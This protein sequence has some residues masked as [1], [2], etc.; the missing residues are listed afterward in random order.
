MKAENIF[1]AMIGMAIMIFAASP[2]H[3]QDC[4]TGDCG[5]VYADGY[6]Y[7]GSVGYL[8]GND[9]A[10]NVHNWNLDMAGQY[11]WHGYNYHR[12]WGAPLALVVPP[13]SAFETEYNWGVASTRSIPIYHQYG[14]WGLTPSSCVGGGGGGFQPTPY[15]PHS[16]S[17]FGVYPVRGPW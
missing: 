3:G 6:G 12:Q 13:T 9:Y 1:A 4:A 8:P 16:T 10:T 14:Y 7:G 5:G 2:I 17:Q 11:P 15:W